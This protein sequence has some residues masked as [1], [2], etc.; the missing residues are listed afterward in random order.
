MYEQFYQEPLSSPTEKPLS[1]MQAAEDE[2][3]V[4]GTTGVTQGT[5]SQNSS[6]QLETVMTMAVTVLRTTQNSVTNSMMTSRQP[7]SV[8][9]QGAMVSLVVTPR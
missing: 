6:T 1:N 7:V 3:L 2:P 8:S 5:E 9:P 4:V